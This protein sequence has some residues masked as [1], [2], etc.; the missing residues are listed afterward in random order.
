VLIQTS[1]SSGNTGIALTYEAAA[2]GYKLNITMSGTMSIE[3]SVL[4][5]RLLSYIVAIYFIITDN[6]HSRVGSMIGLRI[7]YCRR[8]VSGKKGAK[9]PRVEK[10]QATHGCNCFIADEGIRRML[11]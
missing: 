3:Q 4:V 9:S 8:I 1:P 6:W 5:P 11:I 10:I 2:R 7:F